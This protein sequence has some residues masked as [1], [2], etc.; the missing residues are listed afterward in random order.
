MVGAHNT[1]LP[2]SSHRAG[3][4][5]AHGSARPAGYRYSLMERDRWEA[6]W[7]NPR[8]GWPGGT[9][10]GTYQVLGAQPA[11]PADAAAWRRDG[12]PSHWAGSG[13]AGPVSGHPGRLWV[14]GPKPGGAP[15]PL[16][17][18]AT[19]PTD[20]AKLRAIL[21][22]NVPGPS[23][24]KVEERL[25]H[26]SYRQIRDTAIFDNALVVLGGAVRPAVR[27]A[28]FQLLASLPEVRMKPG[29]TDPSGQVTTAVWLNF[30]GGET[31]P[32]LI[33]P[34]TAYVVANESLF[35]RRTDGFAAGTVQSYAL[36]RYQWTN[37]LPAGN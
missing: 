18:F 37:R 15:G 8:P 9:A 27:A 14:N 36:Y 1:V 2:W 23:Q 31:Q 26:E 29:V 12:S 4:Q 19:L 17:D 28:A 34:A 33:D 7:E 21:T 5:A 25:S 6:C 13:S 30:P 20:P 10:G 22:G 3:A 11:T 24:A 32:S 16:G 35:A